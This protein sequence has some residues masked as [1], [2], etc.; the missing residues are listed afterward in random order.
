M[1]KKKAKKVV[2]RKTKKTNWWEEYKRYII[3]SLI[4]AGIGWFFSGSIG[5]GVAVFI[6]VWIG[7]WIGAE[8]L[9]KKK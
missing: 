4:G 5:L 2:H 6:A 3:P 9:S 7:N 8:Y 1:P